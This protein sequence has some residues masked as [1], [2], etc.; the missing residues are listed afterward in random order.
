MNPE[1]P[2]DEELSFGEKLLGLQSFSATRAKRYR[3]ELDQLLVHRISTFERWSMA[4]YSV[5]IGASLIIGGVSIAFAKGTPANANAPFDEARLVFAVTC[6]LTGA[7]LGGWLLRIA[8]QGGYGRRVGDWMGILIALAMCGG[9]GFAF[10]DM[11][12]A[13]DDVSL[14]MKL[15]LAGGA[16]FI[17]LVACVIVACIQRLHRQTQEKLLRIEYHLAELIDRNAPSTPS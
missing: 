8:I 2:A 5:L 16:L 10:I 1:Q 14:R 13:T 4:F 15:L 7:L 9:W 12:W 6:A 11:A 17:I 3:E